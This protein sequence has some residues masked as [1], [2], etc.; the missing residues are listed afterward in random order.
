M[1]QYPHKPRKWAWLA[2]LA[3]HE[4]FNLRVMGSSPMLGVQYFASFLLGRAISAWYVHNSSLACCSTQLLHICTCITEPTVW[5]NCW[6]C[7]KLLINSIRF[8]LMPAQPEGGFAILLSCA[9]INTPY[10][11]EFWVIF[12]FYALW[13]TNVESGWPSGR[14]RQTQGILPYLLRGFWSPLGGVGSNPT[15][16]IACFL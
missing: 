8:S 4:T 1:W 7:A 9:F 15:P 5:N 16:D 10:L 3:E 2:Q 13:F 14:R 12:S 6:F 11:I